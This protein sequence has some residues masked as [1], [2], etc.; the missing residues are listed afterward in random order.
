MLG[1]LYHIMLVPFISNPSQ[2]YLSP[3][4]SKRLEYYRIYYVHNLTPLHAFLS[5]NLIWDTQSNKLS[6]T[7]EKYKKDRGALLD[8]SLVF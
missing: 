6:P 4:F 7:A 3:Y 1:F 8:E 5:D 2:F